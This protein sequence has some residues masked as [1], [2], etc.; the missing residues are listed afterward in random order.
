MRKSI[1][2]KGGRAL[3][4]G[5]LKSNPTPG[6]KGSSNFVRQINIFGE[7][8]DCSALPSKQ[9]SFHIKGKS[10]NSPSI[11]ESRGSKDERHHDD[12]MSRMIILNKKNTF[13]DKKSSMESSPDTSPNSKYKYLT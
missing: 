5:N 13:I 8:N 9:P 2:K 1:Y 11:S 7:G 12:F 10:I 6:A 3:V 4:P